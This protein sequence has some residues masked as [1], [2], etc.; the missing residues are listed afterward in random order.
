MLQTPTQKRKLLSLLFCDE[1]VVE[2]AIACAYQYQH[3]FQNSTAQ[4]R[5]SILQSIETLLQK[6]EQDIAICITGREWKTTC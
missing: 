2:N 5:S 6:Y 4:F 3:E 1:N